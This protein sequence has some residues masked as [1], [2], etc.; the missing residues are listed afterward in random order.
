VYSDWFGTLIERHSLP[1][2]LQVE[3]SL[4]RLRSIL[5][6]GGGCTLED[7]DGLRFSGPLT[8]LQKNGDGSCVATFASDLIWLWERICYPN[9]AL[10]WPAQDADYNTRTGAAETVMLAFIDA[11]AGPGALTARRVSGL[12]LPATGGR[13]GTVTVTARFDSVG[14]LVR[15]MAEAAGLRVRVLQDGANLEVLIDALQDLSAWARYGTADAGGPGI[16]SESWEYTASTP[17]LTRAL[18]AGGGEG[19]ARILRERSDAAA[20]ALWVA[21][22]RYSSTSGTP[23]TQASSTRPEMTRSPTARTPSA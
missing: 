9:P 11:N 18:V 1:D 21:A 13:G 7:D 16:L 22:S 10:S 5:T 23:R 4:D 8:Q 3:G 17:N 15:D 2:T 14:Q 12:T 19:T 20:E 6:P